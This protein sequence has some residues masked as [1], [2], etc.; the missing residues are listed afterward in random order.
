MSIQRLW[1]HFNARHIPLK[2]EWLKEVM[3]YQRLLYGSQ[4]NLKPINF[5]FEQWLCSELS[6]STHSVISSLIS[7]KKGRIIGPLVLQVNWIIDIRKAAYFQLLQMLSQNDV[8]TLTETCSKFESGSAVYLMEVTDGK[9]CFYICDCD[10]HSLFMTFRPGIKVL[11][12]GNIVFRRRVIFLLGLDIQLLG[13]EV[14]RDFYR[15]F[16]SAILFRRLHAVDFNRFQFFNRCT[17]MSMKSSQFKEKTSRYLDI[18]ERLNKKFYCC[19]GRQCLRK[20]I[21]SSKERSSI[22]QAVFDKTEETTNSWNQ[23]SGSNGLT[24][25]M[26]KT[27][28]GS[29]SAGKSACENKVKSRDLV[30]SLKELDAKIDKLCSTFVNY[31]VLFNQVSKTSNCGAYSK[32]NLKELRLRLEATSFSLRI[33]KNLFRLLTLT[34]LSR[35]NSLI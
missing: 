17:G 6:D 8:D 18:A 9:K 1:A 30:T 23:K 7:E 22:K 14:E 21:L 35:S 27:I 19:K 16:T 4:K 5:V 34:R 13:G 10:G 29:S 33:F 28:E 24:D 25:R 2:E 20:M 15:N 32:L 12:H 3:A 11:I 26:N 31:L